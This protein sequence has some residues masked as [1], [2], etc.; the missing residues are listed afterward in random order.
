[1][2]P[3]KRLVMIPGPVPVSQSVL[4]KL[5]SEVKAHTDPE[6][7]AEF[8]QLL[9]ELRSIMNC[10]G[11][12]F[13]VA[14]SGTMAMEMAIANIA[15]GKDKVLVCSNGHFGDRY[16][17]ICKN[18]GLDMTT[19]EAEWG[20][21]VTLEEVDRKLSEG[22]YTVA[23]VTHVETSTGVE[24]P[25]KE[26]AA[27]MKEK[28]PE[29]L[30]VVDGVAAGGGVEVDMSWGID[31][32]FT[33]TQK[34]FCCVPG[35][36]V[37]W[38]GSRALKKREE[39]GSIRESYIDYARWIP[40]M[41]DTRKYWGTPAVN[42]ISALK[43]SVRI[44]LEEGLEERYRRHREHARLIAE[45]MSAIGFRILAKEG[46]RSPTLSIFLYPENMPVD[47]AA[48]RAVCAAEGSLVAACL[49]DYAGKGFRMGHMGN[50]DKHML[51]S[52]V[53]AIERAA[54]SCGLDVEPG[55]ALAVMQ[56]GLAGK[57]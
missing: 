2:I 24:L 32:Y 41:T 27:M 39:M 42:N 36:S 31:V 20:M 54:I 48:F 1:M 16:I 40:V 25:L 6:F 35:M 52:G 12:A 51:I 30:F 43:E 18:R 14:G 5:G 10:D 13:L 37:T 56:R 4:S 55:A 15:N 3:T 7:I 26:M 28:H 34:A 22:K 33:C 53:A 50:L 38:T 47:D 44:M 45:A 46:Y 8:Q 21:S 29:V 17:S 49:G 57:Y 23:V 11:I 9:A 19:L